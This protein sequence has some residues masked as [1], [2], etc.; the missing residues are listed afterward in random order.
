MFSRT[1]GWEWKAT[2]K[3]SLLPSKTGPAKGRTQEVAAWALSFIQ[4]LKLRG[5]AV[6]RNRGSMVAKQ[7]LLVL[8]LFPVSE[9]ESVCHKLLIGPI[10]TSL[11]AKTTSQ[12]LPCE[13]CLAAVAIPSKRYKNV[14]SLQQ[15]HIH[16][17]SKHSFGYSHRRI[18]KSSWFADIGS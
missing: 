8:L 6:I 18:K 17:F 13:T 3:L 9:K 4:D 10:I 1:A 14:S 15:I 16:Y 2:D 7:E 12:P 5:A 11:I